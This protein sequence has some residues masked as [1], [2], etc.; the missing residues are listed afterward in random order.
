MD[1]QWISDRTR[2]LMQ[3]QIFDQNPQANVDPQ[4]LGCAHL[5]WVMQVP[6]LWNVRDSLVASV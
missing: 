4:I 1:Q 6:F 2:L 3:T 5:M